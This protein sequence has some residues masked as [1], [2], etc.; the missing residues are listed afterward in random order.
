LLT[1]ASIKHV[2]IQSELASRFITLR[3]LY[4]GGRSF[5][6][7]YKSY[8]LLAHRQQGRLPL[9]RRCSPGTNNRN[10]MP[11]LRLR[12]QDLSP[13]F[14]LFDLSAHGHGVVQI[15]NL[16]AILLTPSRLRRER[17]L[18]L[19]QKQLHASDNISN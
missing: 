1:G 6:V 13:L 10:V 15:D 12:Y 17:K 9:R 19:A 5:H 8:I 7:E 3:L 18:L 14:V 4:T 2:L 11:P 16:F